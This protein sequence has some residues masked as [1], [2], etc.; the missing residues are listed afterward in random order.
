MLY[1][2]FVAVLIGLVPAAAMAIPQAPVPAAPVTV[3]GALFDNLSGSSTITTANQSAGT[4]GYIVVFHD[5]NYQYS[6]PLCTSASLVELNGSRIDP[7][8]FMVG[9][10][11]VVSVQPDSAAPA[12]SCVTRIVRQAISRGPSQGEC[13]QNY[14]I[15][16]SILNNPSKLLLG[17]TYI[18]N[19][20]AYARPTVDCDGQAYGSSPITTSVAPNQAFTVTLLEGTAQL[21]TWSVTTDAG[22]KASVDYLFTDPSD[23]YKFEVTP[24]TQ[25]APGDVIGWNASVINPTP[26]PTPGVTNTPSTQ[27]GAGPIVIVLILVMLGGGGAEYYFLTRKRARAHELPEDEYRRTRKL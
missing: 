18:Y 12:K 13:L 3:T 22:G 16:H 15:K 19:I 27:V 26:S 20:T 11:L 25:T 9:D 2:F 8:S 24:Q 6:L 23:Q 7:T 5:A 1:R 21:K 4:Q 10:S 17:S 14:Q